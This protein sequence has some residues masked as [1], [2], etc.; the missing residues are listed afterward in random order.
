MQFIGNLVLSAQGD[1]P[2]DAQKAMDKIL[3]TAE[4]NGCTVLG[5]T[6]AEPQGSG[7]AFYDQ[8]SHNWQGAGGWGRSKT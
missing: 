2:D 3:T 5:G 4:Q 1:N 7:A 8:Q 6:L